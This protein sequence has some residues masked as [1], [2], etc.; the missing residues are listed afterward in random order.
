MT[1]LTV[2]LCGT[3]SNSFDNNNPTFWQGELVSTLAQNNQGREFAQWFIVDGPGSGNLQEDDLWV[4]SPNYSDIKGSLFGSGWEENVNHALCLMKG[5]FDWQREKLTEEQYNQLKKAGI[6][7]EDVKVTGSFLWRKYDYGDR[8]VTQQQLQ[9]Q[10]IRIFRKDGII[11]TQV[12][13][14]GWSRGGITCHMLANAMLADSQL[15]DIPVNIFAIDPVPGPLNFQPEKV[16]LGK[17]VKEYVGFYAK[18]ERSKGFTCVIPTVAADTKMH[19][20]PISGRHATLVGN[21]SIDGSEGE[22]ALYAPGLVVRHF[23]EVC[24][25]RWGC[26]LANKLALTDTQIT[27]YHTDI[28]ND[29]DKYTAMRRKTYSIYE[30]TGKD[31]RKVS[32]GKEGKAFSEIVGVQYNPSVGLTADYLSNQQLYDVIK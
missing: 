8:H 21:A 9:Q 27:G 14:V 13:L 4:E 12:N 5:N 1:V 31:E 17:N 22:N 16:T 11:P 6:P 32:L 30:S 20:F 15:K 3:G 19:I 18:D 25:T 26:D 2:Y 23:A 7:I 24:L 29:A 10:I 28:A